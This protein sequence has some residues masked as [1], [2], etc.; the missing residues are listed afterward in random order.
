M[1]TT[2]SII[3]LGELSMLECFFVMEWG[4]KKEE[5]CWETRRKARRR[6]A[7]EEQNEG[8]NE[9]IEVTDKSLFKIHHVLAVL[10]LVLYICIS[11]PHC[12]NSTAQWFSNFSLYHSTLEGLVNTVSDFVLLSWPINMYYPLA[13]LEF[14]HLPSL[15]SSPLRFSL[16]LPFPLLSLTSLALLSEASSLTP[17][18]C[19]TLSTSSVPLPLKTHACLNSGD[20][21]LEMWHLAGRGGDV[22]TNF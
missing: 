14:P 18:A 3:G 15:F 20:T 11:S 21:F 17:F 16:N 7:E 22:Q 10:S 5:N 6:L 1:W 4:R 8:R 2:L 19:L 9:G 12:T 13:I